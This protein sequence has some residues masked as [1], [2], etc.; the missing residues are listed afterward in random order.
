MTVEEIIAQLLGPLPSVQQISHTEETFNEIVKVY[1][2]MYAHGLG[3]FFETG[4]YFFVENGKMTFPKE[5][6]L[7]EQMALFVKILESVQ[8]NDHRQML[9]SGALE[10]SL[11]W[12][13]ART[14]YQ[15]PEN[16]NSAARIALPPDA[17]PTEARID[18]AL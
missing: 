10:T 3:A 6:A 15:T 11:V 17:D 2:E 1:H 16:T 9:Y 12:E 7:I 4:W 14:A 5:A 13:L 8:V 18:F